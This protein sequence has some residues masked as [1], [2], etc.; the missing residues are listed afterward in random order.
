LVQPL[1]HSSLIAALEAYLADI[2]NYWILR[3][4][5]TRAAFVSSNPD[6][7]SR[8]LQLSDIFDRMKALDQEISKYLDQ[9]VWHRLDKAKPMIEQAFSMKVPPIGDL[10]KEV[11]IRHDVVHRG[12]MTKDNQPVSLSDGDVRRV[13]DMILVFAEAID[14]EL[15]RIFP[16][17]PG[18]DVTEDL[19]EIPF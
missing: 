8:K 19:T 5:E 9:F 13:R 1:A 14:A 7:Q 18:G 15:T 10:M 2:A 4:D 3:T 12:G 6:F 17:K 16:P 11:I